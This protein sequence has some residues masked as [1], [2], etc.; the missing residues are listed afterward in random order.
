VCWAT[1]VRRKQNGARCGVSLLG[2]STDWKT[3]SLSEITLS[4]VTCARED[5]GRKRICDA[6]D[7]ISD[8]LSSSC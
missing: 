1:R 3:F 8:L 7:D 4:H 5:G 2:M 6:A